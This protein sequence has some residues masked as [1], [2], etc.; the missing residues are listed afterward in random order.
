MIRQ[1]TDQ[2]LLLT[3]ILF[4]C[5]TTIVII[6]CR[7]TYSTCSLRQHCFHGCSGTCVA[8]PSSG[9]A[10][11]T[12]FQLTSPGWTTDASNFP[13]SYAY[14]Y[15]LSPGGSLLSISALRYTPYIT[16]LS[17][18]ELNNSLSSVPP[19][20]L[21]PT[22]FHL[23]QPY[24]IFQYYPSR[25]FGYLSIPSHSSVP[26]RRCLF[27]R[28][29]CKCWCACTAVGKNECDKSS[30]LCLVYSFYQRKHQFGFSDCQQ[31]SYECE[32]D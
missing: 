12:V 11:T 19:P 26:S 24:R 7:S 9:D 1:K 4:Y 32:C 6:L 27:V 18:Y 13:L 31:C 20:H 29:Y 3:L 21:L 23:L 28:S 5:A 8:T 25:W 22:F 30:F 17:Q 14:A 15:Q 16:F 10:L 2:S